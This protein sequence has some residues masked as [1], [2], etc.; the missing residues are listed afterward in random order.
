MKID[1]KGFDNKL[2]TLDSV[3]SVLVLS[4]VFYT[5]I[6]RYGNFLHPGTS[7]YSITFT[8]TSTTADVYE[9]PADV[10]AT[11]CSLAFIAYAHASLLL[12]LHENT[13]LIFFSAFQDNLIRMFVLQMNQNVC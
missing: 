13:T 11:C 2:Y 3:F 4:M 12:P 1:S 10:R 6:A 9:P 5:V 7:P 8:F